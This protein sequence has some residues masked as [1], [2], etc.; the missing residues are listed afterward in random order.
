[1]SILS[2]KKE[3]SIS[4]TEEEVLETTKKVRAMLE[5]FAAELPEDFRCAGMPQLN[6]SDLTLPWNGEL[7]ISFFRERLKFGG[8]FDCASNGSVPGG[9]V[10]LTVMRWGEEPEQVGKIVVGKSDLVSTSIVS[11]IGVTIGDGVH[12]EPRVTIMDCDGHPADR[13]LPDVPANKK[14]GPVVIEDGA[15]IGYGAVIT[16]GVTIGKNAVVAPGSVVMWDVPEGSAVAGNPAK[17]T[18]VYRKFLKED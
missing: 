8:N 11:Y 13:T 14:M 15:W 6:F 9:P 3:C 1:M 17:S 7:D 4:L 2:M 5:P 10:R 16:K 18:K 12:L